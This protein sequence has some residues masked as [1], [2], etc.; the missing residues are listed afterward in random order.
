MEYERLTERRSNLVIDKCGN[1]ENVR[2]PQ[3]CTEHWCYEV[4]K[5][6]LAELEDKIENGTLIELPC[7]VGDTVFVLSQ[8]KDKRILPFINTYEITSITIRKK[9]I[10]FY[11][12]MDGFIKIF[13]LNDFGETVFLTREKAE[14]K[15]KELEK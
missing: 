14:Q 9:T 1:C 7:K 3:G 13:K 2:N 11:H 15:L 8:M 10:Y 6:R 12:E 5:N 4:M